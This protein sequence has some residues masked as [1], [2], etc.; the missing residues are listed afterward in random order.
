MDLGGTLSGGPEVS[1]F[2]LEVGRNGEEADFLRIK[3][4]IRSTILP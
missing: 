2:V 1:S 4:R 3:A